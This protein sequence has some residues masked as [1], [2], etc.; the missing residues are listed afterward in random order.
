M[1]ILIIHK[2]LIAWNTSGESISVE[3]YLVSPNEDVYI[4][5]YSF[6]SDGIVTAEIKFSNCFD[7]TF[8]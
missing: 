6:E 1:V 7:N 5:I 2:V 4:Y 3:Y 8:F